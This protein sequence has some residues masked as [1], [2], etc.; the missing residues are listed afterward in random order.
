MAL[1]DKGFV[2][3]N[4]VN[5]AAFNSALK[6]AAKKISDLRFP[7]GEISRDFYK[8]EKAI[9]KLGGPG[10]YPDFKT[11]KSKQA[12]IDAGFQPYPL[13]KR[14]GVL[15]KS[16][17]T[18]NAKGSINIIGRKNLVI[19]TAI[20]YGIYHDSDAPRKKIPQRKFVFIA[21]ES[22]GFPSSVGGRLVRWQ[23]II[24]GYVAEVLRLQGLGK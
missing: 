10:A 2:R 7:L 20:R 1:T 24:E 16:I 8:S 17:T 14:T 4:N 22:S 15:E 23:N 21:P 3:L 11:D 12:K 13:L 9:F 18:P 5:H 6:G 19:G